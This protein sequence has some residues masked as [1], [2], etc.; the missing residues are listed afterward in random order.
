M[1]FYQHKKKKMKKVFIQNLGHNFKDHFQSSE[2]NLK[3]VITKACDFVDEIS[4]FNIENKDLNTE[5]SIFKERLINN[6]SVRKM[7]FKRIV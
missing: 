7:L 5:I 1:Y 3:K 6:Y 2:N 4:V